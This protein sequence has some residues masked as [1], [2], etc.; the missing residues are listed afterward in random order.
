MASHSGPQFLNQ[1]LKLLNRGVSCIFLDVTVIDLTEMYLYIPLF[2]KC[3]QILRLG[4]AL[5]IS[6][7]AVFCLALAPRSFTKLMV[8]LVA[9]LW[10]SDLHLYLYL[11]DLWLSGPS[12]ENGAEDLQR[13]IILLW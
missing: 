4:L 12:I 13:T 1:S 5:P 8:S 2:W 11:D 7:N 3:F 9:T 10:R 6:G